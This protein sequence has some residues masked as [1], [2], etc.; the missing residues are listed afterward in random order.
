MFK[1]F[2]KLQVK[3]KFIGQ[4]LQQHHDVNVTHGQVFAS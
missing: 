3:E 4:V 2:K 1:S